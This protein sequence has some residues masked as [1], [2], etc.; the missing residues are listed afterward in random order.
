MCGN[1]SLFVR[2][3]VVA[4]FVA[5]I[6]VSLLPTARCELVPKFSV[7]PGQLETVLFTSK[8][9]MLDKDDSLFKFR[10][11]IKSLFAGTRVAF[12]IKTTNRHD[13]RDYVYA[14]LRADTRGRVSIIV[15]N[16]KL[17]KLGFDLP[18]GRD[19]FDLSAVV[20]RPNPRN[21]RSVIRFLVNST[22]Q[23]GDLTLPEFYEISPKLDCYFGAVNQMDCWAL[24][25]DYF[26]DFFFPDDRLESL[27]MF[28]ADN[29]Y[30]PNCIP[31]RVGN[32][33]ANSLRIRPDIDWMWYDD[34]W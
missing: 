34:Q 8:F 27:S 11:N 12:V 9:L 13:Y 29:Q 28:E 21:H 25:G 5:V 18:T 24:L 10:L 3:I 33:Y 26:I 31:Y 1:S 23:A 4:V 30:P 14:E 22:I 16:R 7:Q 6:I 32:M 19:N 20:V 15:G 2:F 17:E